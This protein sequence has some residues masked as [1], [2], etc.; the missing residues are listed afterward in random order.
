MDLLTTSLL[1]APPAF[2]LGCAA[3]SIRARNLDRWLLPYLQ[4]QLSSRR[5]APGQPVR[6][7]L[8]IADHFEPHNGEVD[9]A[10]ARSRVD[11]WAQEYPKLF[12]HF[13]DSDG[14]PPRHTFYYPLE[15]YDRSEMAA[16]TELCRD[17][18]GEVEVHLHHDNDTSANLRQ[19]LI[20][21]RD[22]LAQR[23]LQL[24]RHRRTGELTYGF[25]HGNWALANCRADGR[26]CGVDDELDI[27]KE[28]GCYADFTFPSAPERTQPRR[29][30]KIYYAN[31][32]GHPQDPSDPSLETSRGETP[33]NGLMLIPGPLTLDWRRRKW[34]LLP[35]IEN[36]CVQSSQPPTLDRLHLW[37]NAGVCLANRPD[38]LF[39]KLH[40]HGAPE[41]NQAIVLGEPMVQFHRAL[42]VHARQHPEFSFHYVTTREMYNLAR[43]AEAGWTGSV[44]AARDFELIWEFDWTRRDG[45]SSAGQVEPPQAKIPVSCA[46]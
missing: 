45:A 6:V 19:R 3:A 29:I 1:C 17:G 46:K 7:L 14:Q 2:A 43:A 4:Q 16:L 33:S 27:L 15:Q 13:R 39:V 38:W 20:E 10:R 32:K 23:H 36:A 41:R 11:R 26:W 22:M 12:G 24:A 5:R 9:D 18:F 35:R 44:D 8:A 25:V 21:Y 30:N 40:T 34:G 28:T 42:A 37:I 31:C